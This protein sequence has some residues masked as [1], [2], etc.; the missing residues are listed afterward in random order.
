MSEE[1]TIVSETCD[2][3]PLQSCLVCCE[4]DELT[5][6]GCDCSETKCKTQ[7]SPVDSL[8]FDGQA[9][10]PFSVNV[11]E[12]FIQLPMDTA[13]PVRGTGIKFGDEEYRVTEVSRFGCNL[14][15]SGVNFR[16][17]CPVDAQ[18]FLCESSDY[19]DEE[20]DKNN[21]GTIKVV[22]ASSGGD[23]SSAGDHHR[24]KREARIYPIPVLLPCPNDGQSP[25]IEANRIV[26][27]GDVQYKITRIRN[28]GLVD[29]A[30]YYEA[31]EGDYVCS[32][33][34]V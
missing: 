17:P 18:V 20:N 25:K 29:R 21:L 9:F 6:V 10:D 11:R 32:S 13:S 24:I 26:Q 8:K 5:L 30:A 15:V 28:D 19:C 12:F 33:S 22:V 16:F 34:P 3:S 27:V 23:L 1:Q 31:E 4:P 7:A 14:I 2:C